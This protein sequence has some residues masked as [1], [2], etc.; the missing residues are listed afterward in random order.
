[1]MLGCRY[2]WIDAVCIVRGDR[3]DWP[4][5]LASMALVCSNASSTIAPTPNATAEPG[6]LKT[7]WSGRTRTTPTDSTSRSDGYV[8]RMGSWAVDRRGAAARAG[9]VI[10]TAAS[11][12]VLLLA[13]AAAVV[14]ST[15]IAAGT[16]IA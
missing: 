7:T 14:G 9:A 16:A 6:S 15:L 11:A 2:L 3:D 4:R 5:E 1:M 12:V 13:A 8:S 10:G